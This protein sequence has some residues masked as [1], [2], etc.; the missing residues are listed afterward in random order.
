MSNH[1]QWLVSANR[2]VVKIGSNSV[3]GENEGKIDQLVDALATVMN[4][5]AEVVL[6][7]SLRECRCLTLMKNQQT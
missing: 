3:T 5:G 2:I 7:S 4:R 1:G 6:V